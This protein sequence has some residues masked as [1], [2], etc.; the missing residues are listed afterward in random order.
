MIAGA[1]GVTGIGGSANVG[2]TG[3]DGAA[4]VKGERLNQTPSI[5]ARTIKAAAAS[6]RF[7]SF[8]VP[9]SSH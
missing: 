8:M 9:L 5:R 7:K 4:I 2:S 6:A 1:A 3:T